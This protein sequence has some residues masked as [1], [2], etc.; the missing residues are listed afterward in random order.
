MKLQAW[1][2]EPRIIEFQYAVDSRGKTPSMTHE[3][4]V[5]RRYP[6]NTIAGAMLYVIGCDCP[7]VV[8]PDRHLVIWHSPECPEIDRD[9]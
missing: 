5:M 3:V 9:A 4:R 2:G 8:H 1:S 7:R 6:P